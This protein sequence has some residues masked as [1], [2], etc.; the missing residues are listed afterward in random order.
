MFFPFPYFTLKLFC[1]FRIR[2]L[3]CFSALL[4]LLLSL[5]L[6]LLNSTSLCRSLTP[7]Q[8]IQTTYSEP[9]RQSFL[10]KHRIMQLNHPPY[11]KDRAPCDIFFFNFTAQFHLLKKF[12]T[13][14]G[15]WKIRR[16]KS[17]GKGT[18]LKKINVTAIFVSIRVNT[19]S[20]SILFEPISY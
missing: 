11:S 12:Q 15:K 9:H 17:N 18:I 20:I 13:Y 8:G 2:L 6:L 1:F 5:L 3:I 16:N 4:L 10:S 7:L 19:T 14:R